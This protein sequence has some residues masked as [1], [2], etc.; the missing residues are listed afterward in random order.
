M[1]VCMYAYIYA[2]IYAF[3]YVYVNRMFCKNTS[4]VFLK[5]RMFYPILCDVV[6]RTFSSSAVVPSVQQTQRTE[7]AVQSVAAYVP[8]DALTPM[9]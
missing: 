8:N 3:I 9:R 2:Y 1:Y 4:Q 7:E 5:K 6:V